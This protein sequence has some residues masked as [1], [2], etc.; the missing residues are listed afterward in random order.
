MAETGVATVIPQAVGRDRVGRDRVVVSAMF[1]VHGMVS[2][3]WTGRIPWVQEHIH[4]S[5]GVLGGTMVSSTVGALVAMPR[6]GAV[7]R[8]FGD[9]AALRL[10][11]GLW[12]ACLA[13]PALMPDAATL[14][15]SLF[16]FGASAGLADVAMNAAGV[17]VERRA[18][19]SIMSGLH[20][21]WAVGVLAGSALG[22]LCAR[23]SIGAPAELITV[24]ILLTA[25][26]MV[27]PGLLSIESLSVNLDAEPV[28]GPGPDPATAQLTDT[29]GLAAAQTTASRPSRRARLARSFA[30]PSR[31]LLGIALVGFCAI[32][33][34]GACNNWSA[35]YLVT[36]AHTGQA[37]AAFALTGF[38]CTMAIGRLTGDAVVRRL[39]PVRTVRLGGVVALIGSTTVVFGH[40]PVLA[41]AGFVLTGLGIATTV[42][43]AFAAS[44]RATAHAESAIASI[45]TVTY[46]AGLL[47]DPTVGLLGSA[48]SLSFA[49]GLVAL[50]TAGLI[51]G[52]GALGDREPAV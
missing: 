41:I 32:F 18:G 9:R 6:A 27:L 44:G 43:L 2:G 19:K 16:F 22:A 46:T 50:L 39:G 4:A 51:F 8:R 3:T 20:G 11:I 36:V 33:A 10:L 48:V 1:V 5:L 14:A 24:A 29:D 47:A 12:T 21:L 26:A 49:F 40:T 25:V 38:A 17:R 13:L 30:L 28:A 23:A 37:I 31:A 35:V 34:E 7:V 52:A 42:P 45:A 15:V